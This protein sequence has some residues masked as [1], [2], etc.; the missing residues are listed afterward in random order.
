MDL[1]TLIPIALRSSIFLL[2]FALGLGANF[3][4]ALSLLRRPAQ[5]LRS[6]VAMNVVMPVFA[7]LLAATFDL[8]YIVKVALIALAV[9]PV[10]PI[11]P[12]KQLKAGGSAHYT[13]GLLF[14]AALLTIV[15]LPLSV[16]IVGRVFDKPTHVSPAT[17]ALIVSITVIA[18]LAAGILVRHLA[19]RVAER[20]AAPVSLFAT[21][22]LFVGVLPIVFAAWPAAVSLV[23]NG[24]LAA[25]T[26]FIVAGLAAGH[27]LGGP[28]PNDRVVLALATATRHPGVAMAVAHAVAP[29]NKLVLGAVLWYLIVGLIVSAAYLA[30][31]RRQAD[32]ATLGT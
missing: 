10:P 3:D 4:E 19:P 21:V 14:S 32:T 30:W 27:F 15:S 7:V 22:A 17:V 12:K 28:D 11:L 13:V 24:T 5:L 16:E 18:P 6:L 26:V 29:G 9:S 20:I 1:A 2:V 8:H 25:I 31:R 23:G